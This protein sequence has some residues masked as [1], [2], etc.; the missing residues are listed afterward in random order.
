[1]TTTWPKNYIVGP[2]YGTYLK[3]SNSVAKFYG[4]IVGFDTAY[5]VY[6]EKK[7]TLK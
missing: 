3:D 7:D 1:M 5:G 4:F 6:I 2:G